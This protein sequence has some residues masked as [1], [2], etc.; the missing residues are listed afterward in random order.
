MSQIPVAFVNDQFVGA[1]DAKISPLDRGFLF[2]DGVYEVIPVHNGKMFHFEAHIHRLEQSLKG[3]GM[4]NPKTLEEWHVL[5]EQL[6]EK[7]NGGEQWLYL[8]VTRGVELIRN[9]AFPNNIMPTVFAISYPKPKIPKEELSKGLK[10]TTV[11]DIRWKYCHIKTTAR[12]AYVLMYQEA[13]QAGFDEAIIVNNGYA[14]EGTSSNIFIVRHGVIITPPKSPL[15]LS[16]ITRDY[17]LSL[18]EKYKIPYRENKIPERDLIKADEIWITSST[19]G[20]VPVVM[21]DNLPIGKGQ[22]GPLWNKLWDYY[23]AEIAQLSLQV[24]N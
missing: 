10:V 13:K 18:A 14:Y 7:N 15:L 6:I 20:V 1:L 9:H 4:N 22:A 23:A 12:L 17:L 21:L 24:S 2:G 3:I 5:L 8:Q 16:G 11:S 19:R